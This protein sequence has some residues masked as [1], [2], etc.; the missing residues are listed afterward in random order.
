MKKH[1][2]GAE[3]EITNLRLEDVIATSD[4]FDGGGFDQDDFDNVDPGGWT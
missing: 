2:A 1:Y 3:I 4:P